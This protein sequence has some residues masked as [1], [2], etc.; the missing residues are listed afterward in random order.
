MLYTGIYFIAMTTAIL[1][2]LLHTHAVVDMCRLMACFSGLQFTQFLRVIREML[3]K[4]EGEHEA[5]LQQL[6]TMEEQTK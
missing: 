3:Q 5:Y 2:F 4:V 1:Y 6:S